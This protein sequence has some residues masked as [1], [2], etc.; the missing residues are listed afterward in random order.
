[1]RE[2]MGFVRATLVALPSGMLALMLFVQLVWPSP[3]AALVAI[4]FNAAIF[5]DFLGPYWNTAT[6]F[7][8]GET[9]PAKLY[10]YP[11]FFAWVLTPLVPLGPLAAAWA[12]AALMLGSIATLLSSA[13][14]LRPAPGAAAAAALGVAALLAQPVVHGIYWGQAGL[15]TIALSA[16]AFAAWSRGRSVAGG[17][18]VGI[19]AAIKLT[20]LVFLIAP[21][22]RGDL[23]AL[24][25]GL[26]TFVLAAVALPVALMGPGPALEFHREVGE[27]LAWMAE[28]T[29]TPDGGAGSQHMGA[30]FVR[31]FGEGWHG[32][33]RIVGIGLAL[34]CAAWAGRLL[35]RERPDWACAF[36]SLAA[37]PWL[38]VGPTWAH[39]LAWIVV[40]WWAVARG[41][42]AAWAGVALAASWAVGSLVALRVAGSPLTYPRLGLPALAA[43]LSI[44]A[45]FGVARADRGASSQPP[46]DS[47][48][49]E[50]GT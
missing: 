25:A 23:R 5:E 44:A 16:A 50:S 15:I 45:T 10:L 42:P 20:P 6:G 9:E 14:A 32:V 26:L 17:V 33:G 43:A 36:A 47:S 38:V 35:R 48:G 22:L 40:A 4:D 1:M 30:L 27:R 41:H 11:A 39:G 31:A 24:S 28:I 37:I 7:A 46:G 13:F 29:A 49:S 12:C 2:P 21:A 3:E 8:R 18:V 34:G 19:A